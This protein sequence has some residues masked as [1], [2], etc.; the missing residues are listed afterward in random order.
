MYEFRLWSDMLRSATKPPP[1]SEIATQEKKWTDLWNIKW[2]K[3]KHGHSCNKGTT[4]LFSGEGGLFFYWIWQDPIIF[5][6]P[7]S[8]NG[9]YY[10]IRYGGRAGGHPHRFPHNNFNSVCRI[11]TKFDH[12]IAM[13][14]GKNP[15]YFG[16]ITIIPFDNLYRQAYFVMHTFLV[17]S[18][19]TKSKTFTFMNTGVHPIKKATSKSKKNNAILEIS[20]KLFT[21]RESIVH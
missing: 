1:Q 21:I 4:I 12:I 3:D 9:P 2:N 5:I 11:F 19:K 14:K 17:L 7:S 18:A 8:Q 10:V 6:C 15:I 13:W 16:V 20:V